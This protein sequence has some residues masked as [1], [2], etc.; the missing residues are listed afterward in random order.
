M[1]SLRTAVV[2]NR[3]ASELLPELLPEWPGEPPQL[4]D[5][6]TV[7]LKQLATIERMV[8]AGGD[9][10]IN[11]AVN[12]LCKAP[13]HAVSLGLMPLGTGNDFAT[14]CG[15]PANDPLAAWAAMQSGVLHPVDV[16][17]F[18]TLA[19]NVS[20]TPAQFFVNA[21]TGGFGA[22]VTANTPEEIKAILGKTAYTFHALTMLL[23][24]PRREL[25]LKTADWEWQGDILFLSIANGRRAGGGFQIA[26]NALLNDRLLDVRVIPSASFLDSP[27][28]FL[29]FLFGNSGP[30]SLIQVL[31]T[32]WIELRSDTEFQLSID[33]EPCST[34]HC[35]IEIAEQQI[36]I[37]LPPACPLVT[38]SNKV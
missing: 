9:G 13:H 35:R 32:P 12:L 5:S 8:A 11:L 21:I 15:L 36:P 19:D 17:R 30:D 3:K 1:A 24:Q 26:P 27:G 14:A 23:N 25:F 29:D 31:Q 34:S 33:G 37:W 22:E 2:Q 38:Q 4:W 16:G 18:T 6:R 7:D 10:T 20:P 28:L